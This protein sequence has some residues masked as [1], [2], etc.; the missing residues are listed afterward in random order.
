MFALKPNK[1]NILKF[2]KQFPNKE[3]CEI[4]FKAQREKEGIKCK[5][6][7]GTVHYWLQAKQQWQCKACNFRTTLRSGTV[8]ESAKLDMHIW[9]TAM[10]LISFTKKGISC[11][12]LQRQL[13]LSRYQTTLRLYHKLRVAMGNRDARYILQ[14]MVELDEGYFLIEDNKRKSP[15]NKAGKGSTNVQNVLVLAESNPLEDENFVVNSRCGYFKFTVL[16]GHDADEITDVV[17]E[18][19]AS[20]T[21]IVSDMSTSYNNLE[22]V[23]EAHY[24]KI[25]SKLTTKTTLKWVHLAINNAKKVLDGIY[26]RVSKEYLQLYLDEFCYKLNRRYCKFNLFDRL[27]LAVASNCW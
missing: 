3:S 24:S 21:V 12:E 25:S 2:L 4:H 10:A 18:N 20:T 27:A 13:G 19:V 8:M 9:Y 6:C 16:D 1:M 5:K 22:Q 23:I 26:Q 15:K 7:N 11:N 17:K 14:D